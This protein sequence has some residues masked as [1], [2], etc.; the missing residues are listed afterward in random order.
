MPVSYEGVRPEH[1]AVRES[2]GAFDVSHMGE[3]ETDGPQAA[4][5]LQRLLTNDVAALDVGAA[6]YS[7][8]CPED[9]GVL[10]DVITYRVE[11]DRYLTV[12]NAANRERDF[13]WFADHAGGLDA[14]VRD[15][16]D[17]YAMLAVQGPAARGLLA[18]LADRELPADAHRYR[19]RR[20]GRCARVRHRVHG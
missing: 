5:L 11:R 4:E 16:G 8:L 20:G 13:E 1:L 19:A 3:I 7:C 14:E 18:S 9:G 12:A 10:D 15:V 6:Q 17:A 2:A